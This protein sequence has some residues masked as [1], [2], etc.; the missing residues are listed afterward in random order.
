MIVTDGRYA[1]NFCSLSTNPNIH[2]HSP[3]T[4]GYNHL[5]QLAF[6]LMFVCCSRC[7]ESSSPVFVVVLLSW[8]MR[9]T[10]TALVWASTWTNQVMVFCG[11][12]P[13]DR[14]RDNRSGCAFVCGFTGS[15]YPERFLVYLLILPRSCRI[16]SLIVELATTVTTNDLGTTLSITLIVVPKS[17]VVI[18]VADST[19]NEHMRWI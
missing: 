7:F 6:G 2:Y 14:K 9:T 15:G 16:C 5:T 11:R 8:H 4:N 3:H 13:R 12:I 1:Q 10:N 17:L 19:I 18:V